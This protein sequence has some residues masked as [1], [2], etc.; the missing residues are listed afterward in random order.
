VSDVDVGISDVVKHVDG[1]LMVAFEARHDRWGINTDFIYAALSDSSPTPRE[2][3]FTKAKADLDEI[4]WT[5]TLA[6]TV[7]RDDSSAIDL[8]GGFRLMS[9]NF[10][11]RL[12]GGTLP[13]GAPVDSRDLSAGRTWIDPVF[14]VRGRTRVSPDTFL[15]AMGDIGGFGASSQLTWQALAAF[16]YDLSE[17]T[18]LA[19]GYRALG[20]NHNRDSF[21]ND[22]TMF[23]PF[24]G[25]EFRF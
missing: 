21:R 7:I 25:G 6:Y 18:S 4:I 23:G 3:A 8:L 20:Y 13:S 12:D 19:I 1:G 22:L 10:D 15:L 16:G 5:Q 11:L 17:A 14:G 2:V 9:I 24:L